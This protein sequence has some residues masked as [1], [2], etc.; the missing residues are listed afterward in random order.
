VTARPVEKGSEPTRFGALLFDVC[1]SAWPYTPSSPP[2]RLLTFNVSTMHLIA[3]H[4]MHG[5]G[6]GCRAATQHET[7]GRERPLLLNPAHVADAFV[8]L[9]RQRRDAWTFE[10]DLRPCME[11][12]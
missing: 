10:L 12:W 2:G 3:A 6:D 11:R 1:S 7:D 5:R 4:C 8:A 9:H